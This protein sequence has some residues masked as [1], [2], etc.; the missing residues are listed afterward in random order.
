MIP[1]SVR[2]TTLFP[3]HRGQTAHA[4]TMESKKHAAARLLSAMHSHYCTSYKYTELLCRWFFSSAIG[5]QNEK[6][7]KWIVRKKNGY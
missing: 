3:F 6:K 4:T 5:N 2:S 7:K 1:Q